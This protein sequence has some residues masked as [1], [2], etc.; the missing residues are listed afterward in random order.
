MENYFATGSLAG[1]FKFPYRLV[2]GL[3][4]NWATDISEN[5]LDSSNPNPRSFPQF[6]QYQRWK[7]GRRGLPAARLLRWG[8]RGCR[9]GSEGHDDVRVA[10]GD[11]W[12]R[13]VHVRRRGS[14]SA[15]RSPAYSR[16]DSSIE[17]VRELHGMLGK[18]W[19]QG[20]RQRLTG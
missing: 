8:G 7:K 4:F 14:S 1:V 2:P 12:S 3:L 17:R 9:G 19:V 6:K 16:R 15:A 5:P 10:V 11:G 18:T 13:P 20:I